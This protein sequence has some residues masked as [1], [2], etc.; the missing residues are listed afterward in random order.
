MSRGGGGQG[1]KQSYG[2]KRGEKMVS[3]KT[4]VEGRSDGEK[5]GDKSTI[6]NQ[7]LKTPGKGNFF[8]RNGEVEKDAPRMRKKEQRGNFWEY[9]EFP[10]RKNSG[11]ELL[12]TCTKSLQE[13]HDLGSHYF[14]RSEGKKLGGSMKTKMLAERKRR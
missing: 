3:V 14:S 8:L 1:K 2:R 12:K 6:R 10:G 5:N 4:K 9:Q 11:R 13:S 7:M